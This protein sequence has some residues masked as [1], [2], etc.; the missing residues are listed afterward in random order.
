MAT[1]KSTKIETSDGTISA[2]LNITDS[3]GL[4]F[5]KAGY[6]GATALT[7]ATSVSW[8]AG[9]NQSAVLVLGHNATMGAATNQA[10]GG[11]YILKVTQNTSAKTLRENYLN[12]IDRESTALK[13]RKTLK[14]GRYTTK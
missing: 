14:K 3:T 2:N 7:S 1:L 11:V 4:S 8:D 6:F 10:N 13:G 5:T 9:S 12:K